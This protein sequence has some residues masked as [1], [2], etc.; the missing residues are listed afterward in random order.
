MQSSYDRIHWGYYQL[1]F[2]AALTHEALVRIRY[3]FTALFLAGCS[4]AGNAQT[5]DLDTNALTAV[6]ATEAATDGAEAP[7]K[8]LG[9]FHRS[10]HDDLNGRDGSTYIPVDSWI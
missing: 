9:P 10:L 6:T 1:L 8:S 3:P 7:P 4:L 5:P 2:S